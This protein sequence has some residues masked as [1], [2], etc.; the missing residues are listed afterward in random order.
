M[1]GYITITIDSFDRQF[2]LKLLRY[3]TFA[4]VAHP[5]QLRRGMQTKRSSGGSQVYS[6]ASATTHSQAPVAGAEKSSNSSSA[7]IL[8]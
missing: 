4:S 2:A 7:A 5:R 3:P 8:A 1:I 6:N